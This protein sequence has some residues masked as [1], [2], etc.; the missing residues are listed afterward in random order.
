MCAGGAGQVLAVS[1]TARGRSS[2]AALALPFCIDWLP[3]GRLLVV[4]G[5]EGRALRRDTD[6][7]S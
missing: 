3:D 5:R 6:G 1:P 7:R 4:E 2:S